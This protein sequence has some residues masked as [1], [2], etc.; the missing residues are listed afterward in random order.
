[1]ILC[2]FLDTNDIKNMVSRG[3]ESDLQDADLSGETKGFDLIIAPK[4]IDSL[5]KVSHS[6]YVVLVWFS[7]AISAC[8]CCCL[9]GYPSKKAI[10]RN[11]E[12]VE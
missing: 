10:A 5:K 8:F 4:V 2:W 6:W 7:A 1:M 9:A 11:R 3:V 12:E